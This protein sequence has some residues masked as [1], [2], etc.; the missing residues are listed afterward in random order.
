MNLKDNLKNIRKENNLS[1]EELAEKLGVS[2]QAVSKWESGISYPE[3]DKVI[4][5]CELFNLN[6]DEL[7]NKNIKEVEKN[8]KSKLNINKYIDDFLNYISKTIKMFASMTFKDK[9]KCLFEQCVIIFALIVI[10]GLLGILLESIFSNIIFLLPEKVAYVLSNMLESIYY[11]I[12]VIMSVI[13]VV[14]V[15]KTRYLNYC[16]EVDSIDIY[17][18]DKDDKEE[19]TNE[20]NKVKNENKKEKITIKN[21]PRIIIRDP[22]HS[23]YRFINGIIKC[24]VFVLKLL[25]LFIGL[26]FCFS[27]VSLVFAFVISFIISKTGV[28]FF[29]VLVVIISCILANYVILTLLYNF[30]INRKCKKIL[31]GILLLLSLT[32]FGAGCGISVLGLKSFNYLDVPS[33]KYITENEHHYSMQKDLILEPIFNYEYVESDNKDIK[34]VAKTVGECKIEFTN[35]DKNRMVGHYYCD[36]NRNIKLVIDALNNKEIFDYSYSDVKIY[37]TKENISILK[38]NY[39]NYVNKNY[40]ENDYEYY[41]E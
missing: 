3:M 28:F 18:D 31:T 2:R 32:M 22:K 10:F 35:Y 14:Y 7:L 19:I 39:K 25:D 27:F 37:T 11:L 4:Q 15:F 1:Q 9:I 26:F 16:Y 34:I 17:E 5:L 12:A 20:E 21:E 33:E 38:N 29:G 36:G 23:E 30:L 41:D 40:Y 24:L 13:V 8:N 6:I